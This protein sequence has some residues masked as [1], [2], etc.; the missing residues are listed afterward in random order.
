MDDATVGSV[1]PGG[2]TT[3]TREA[4]LAATRALLVEQGP[5]GM[6]VELIAA[7]SGV[8]RS[9]IYRRWR[10]PAGIIADLAHEISSGFRQPETDSLDG[11]LL[12]VAQQLADHLDGDG[13]ALVRALGAWPERDVQEILRGFWTARRSDMAELLHRHGSSADPAAVLRLL[14]GPLHYQATIERSPITA[15]AIQDAATAATHRA[16]S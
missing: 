3:R 6:R 11:D 1:R 15:A 2:R 12:A 7:R 4:V 13:A 8:H 14:A 5:A 16:M 9:S 10:T